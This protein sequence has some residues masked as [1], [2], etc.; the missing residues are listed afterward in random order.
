MEPLKT[1]INLFD[2]FFTCSRWNIG[3]LNQTPQEL[4]KAKQLAGKVTWLTE[5]D[6]DYA[7]DPFPVMI[8][9]HMHLYYEELNFWKGKGELML[10][11]SM[12]FKSKEKISAL[13]SNSVHLSYPYTFSIGGKIY[14]VPESSEANEVV[15]Y[16]V[17]VDKPQKFEKLNV[18]LTGRFVD[19]S[20]IYYNEKYWLF[21]SKS[22]NT[23]LL[24]I[25]HADSLMGK[26]EPHKQNPIKVNSSMCRS[27]GRLFIADKKLY[28]PSQNH[29]KCYGGSVV[30]N[31]ITLLSETEFKCASVFKIGA[32]PPYNQG[33]HTIN[34][35][36]GLL[37]VD[38]KRKVYSLINP[39]KKFV[40]KVRNYIN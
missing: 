8:N 2:K 20:I 23:N 22:K 24:Y 11:N 31:E 39:L 3:Y 13:Y 36:N 34:F 26:F 9:G 30:I 21:N 32:Q 15:L 14:C 1:F 5:D 17:N 38:G 19:S 18:L 10:L 37:I 33:L 27:A 25:F 12:S 40:R 29:Q 4:I 6:V 28:M 7:A 35:C 16:Q